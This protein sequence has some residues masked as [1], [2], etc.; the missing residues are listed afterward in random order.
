MPWFNVV[1]IHYI[2]SPTRSDRPSS[3]SIR[4]RASRSF[5]KTICRRDPIGSAL[6]LNSPSS[7]LRFSQPFLGGT[8]EL[9]EDMATHECEETSEKGTGLMEW[10][11]THPER[12]MR[13]SGSV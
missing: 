5:T 12:W 7:F 8:T 2:S 1:S 9:F 13:A 4:Q 6:P 10:P 11:F 3:P